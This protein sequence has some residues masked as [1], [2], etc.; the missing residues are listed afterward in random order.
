MTTTSR[1]RIDP[2]TDAAVSARAFAA[3][4]LPPVCVISGRGATSV[5][6][7]FAVAPIDRSPIGLALLFVGGIFGAVPTQRL[8]GEVPYNAKVAGHDP[9]Y[10]SRRKRLA[11]RGLWV[12]LLGVA[13]YIAA[14]NELLGTELGAFLL[15]M[16]GILLTVIGVTHLGL[17]SR[18]PITW[19]RVIYDV[20]D[21]GLVYIRDAHPNFVAAL[22]QPASPT[23][24]ASTWSEPMRPTEPDS[25]GF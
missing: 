3:G 10:T 7:R 21:S 6:R 25:P 1:G 23:T 24:R 20:E 4:T 2:S 22:E 16:A 5:E 15:G 9:R 11:I 19:L 17:A 18:R 14:I 8:Q 13:A 12:G